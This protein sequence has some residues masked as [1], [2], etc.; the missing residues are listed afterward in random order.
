MTAKPRILITRRWP[1]AVERVLAERFD[2]VLN[3]ED[4]P[5]DR[6]ALADALRNFD[7]VLRPSRT[8]CRPM[9]SRAEVFAPGSSAIS[10]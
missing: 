6:S 5:L 1:Q 10:A 7:A 2:T 9:F 3:E 4:R 8:G